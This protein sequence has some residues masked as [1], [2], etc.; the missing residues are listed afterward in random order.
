MIMIN[1]DLERLTGLRINEIKDERIIINR[2]P[3]LCAI[4]SFVLH[5]LALN[6]INL[7]DQKSILILQ[8][9]KCIKAILKEN[10]R[11]NDL[12]INR[13]IRSF[14]SDRNNFLNG[15][16][17]S[18]LGI[19]TGIQELVNTVCIDSTRHSLVLSQLL[20]IPTRDY[21]N[22]RHKIVLLYK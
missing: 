13:L 14:S 1:T 19:I 3:T 16:N 5:E 21:I 12:I 9:I 17:L 6:L 18:Q 20:D 8:I 7:R 11:R 4:Q 22:S 15:H 10:N 2:L